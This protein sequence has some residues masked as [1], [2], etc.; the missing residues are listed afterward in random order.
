M[1]DPNSHGANPDPV[2]PTKGPEGD[3]N[4]RE[5]EASHIDHDYLLA[6]GLT[7]SGL[8]PS[9]VK[10]TYHQ[11]RQTKRTF[12]FLEEAILSNRYPYTIMVI[13]AKIGMYVPPRKR[14]GV[15]TYNF[16]INNVRYYET[17]FD[18]SGSGEQVPSIYEIAMSKDKV[19]FLSRFKDNEILRPGYK[20]SRN[21]TTRREMINNFITNNIIVHGQF[22][23]ENCSQPTY[24][25]KVKVVIYED[26]A[27][28]L[29]YS[30]NDLLSLCD[31]SRG[32][33]W[34]DHSANVPFSQLSLHHLRQQILERLEQW[35]Q[36]DGYSQPPSTPQLHSLLTNLEVLLAS[37]PRSEISAYLG[38]PML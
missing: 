29:Q 25:T 28:R 16:F 10:A 4:V 19:A 17:V 26:T 14:V 22:R 6:Y 27:V 37:E 9:E 20:F 21:Y 30:T 23:L 36:R 18:R 5:G 13:A 15:T 8:S 1:S 7:P 3:A 34:K 33:V 24:G 11:L 31:M 2:E 12:P 35:R 38:N 32:V